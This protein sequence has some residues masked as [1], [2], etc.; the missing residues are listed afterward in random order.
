LEEMACKIWEFLLCPSR[1]VVYFFENCI[2]GIGTV[3]VKLNSLFV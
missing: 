2:V 3:M 1:R